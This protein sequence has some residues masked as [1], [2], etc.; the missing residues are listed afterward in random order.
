MGKRINFLIVSIAITTSINSLVAQSLASKQDSVVVWRLLNKSDKYFDLTKFDSALIYSRQA[1]LYSQQHNYKSGETWSIIKMND[2]LLEKDELNEAEKN[3]TIIQRSGTLMKDSTIIGISWLH[4]G[5][6]Q[7]YNNKVDSA[8]YY[9][10]KALYQKLENVKLSYTGHCYNELGYAWGRKDNEAKMMEFCLKG[11]AVYESIGDAVGCAMT[12]GNIGTIYGRLGQKQKAIE[13]SKQ[14]LVY[15][16][17]VGDFN[18]LSL[19]CSNL[20]RQYLYIN[21]DSA[22]KYQRLCENYAQQSGIEHRIAESYITS[23]VVANV[24]GKKETAYESELKAVRILETS[25]ADLWLLA[26]QYLAIAYYAEL[27]L[28]DSSLILSYYDKGIQLAEQ[29][30]SKFDLKNLYQYKSDFYLAQKIYKQAYSTYKKHILYKDSLSL[31]KQQENIFEL[32]AKYQTAKKDIEIERLST[33]QTIKQLEIEKQKAL[34]NGNRLEAAQKQNEINLL[35]QQEQVQNLRLVKQREELDK[36]S[37]Q[38]KNKEQELRLIQKERLLNEKQLQNQKQLRNGIIAGT[39]LL[40]LVAGISFSRYKLKKKLQQQS[41]LQ[42]MRNHIASDLHDDIGASLSNIS[43][44]NELTKRNANEP[45]KV[46]EYLA[47]A[48]EDIRTV[49]EGISDIVWNIN[50]R[51][52][53]LEQLFIKMKRYASDILDAKNIQY[54]ITFPGKTI[55]WKLEMDKRRDFYLVFKEAINNMA[56]YSKASKA[57][58][59]C[60]V[61][62]HQVLLSIADNGIGFDAASVAQGNGLQNM[63]QRAKLLKARLIIDTALNKGTRLQLEMPV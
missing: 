40:L 18:K 33:E 22:V 12:L 4:K 63:K 44:L 34:I 58:I 49:S 32:E 38:S 24:Q 19:V 27:L 47:K 28:M 25:K 30:K 7:L 23:A 14:S 3:A 16:Q 59:E 9:F 56:K 52:D 26:N 48:S 42:E 37:L 21:I 43:I 53:D 20:S 10:E 35:Q 11:F 46:S 6:V 15:R 31:S 50:P 8:I 13:Y 1:F 39:L 62:K 36:Q 2:A 5:Q 55:E 17:K 51:F 61:E 57:T 29:L 54:E 45:E 60:L 41:E